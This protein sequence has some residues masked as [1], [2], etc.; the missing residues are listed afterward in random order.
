MGD[1]MVSFGNLSMLA[2]KPSWTGWL[3]FIESLKNGQFYENASHGT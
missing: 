2:P 1:S 3:D